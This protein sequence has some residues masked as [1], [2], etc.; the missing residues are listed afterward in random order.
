MDGGTVPTIVEQATKAAAA[1]PLTFQW[2]LV[3]VLAF[4]LAYVV[5]FVR[6]MPWSESAKA[7]KPLAC[8]ACMVG[9]ASIAAGIALGTQTANVAFV[10]FHVVP[11]AGVALLILAFLAR[12]RV[13]PVTL[14]PPEE[15]PAPEA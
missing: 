15:P 14:D 1:A 3:A 2:W 8:D 6:A 4:S 9:W 12:R 7:A 11:A 13:A 5:Q 10:L